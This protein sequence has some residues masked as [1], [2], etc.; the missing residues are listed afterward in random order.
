MTLLRL[1]A[2]PV[3][4]VVLL[5][6]A[7][8]GGGGGTPPGSVL[9]IAKAPTSGDNQVGPAGQ[10]LPTPLAAIVKDASSNPVAGQTVT[11]A[12]ASGG[13]SVNPASGTTAAS[14][15][16]TTV[17]T[18]GPGASSQTATAT[19]TSATGSPL[20]FTAVAQIQ[21][22]TQMALN[23]GSGQQDTI[24][25]AL[26]TPYSVVVRDQNNTAVPGVV[27]SWSASGGGSVSAATSTTNASGIASVTR[28]LGTTVGT[29]TAQ[30]AVTGLTGSP[31]SFT[32]TATAGN[33]TKIAISGGDNQTAQVNSTLL[34][35]YSVTARDRGDN[36]KSG[37]AVAWAVAS[38]GG[39]VNP[40]SSAT[41]ANGVAT[42]VRTL[43][44]TAGTQTATATAP[45]LTGSPLTFTATA[46]TAPLTGAVTVGPGTVFAPASVTIGVSGTVTW[47]WAAGS[48]SHGVQWLTGSPLPA[49]SA[50]QSSGTYMVTFNNAGTYTYDCLVHGS[51]M[52]GTIIVQ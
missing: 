43:G 18:L 4:G 27:V 2:W 14:G 8:G 39:S 3:V 9:T 48:L 7:C 16:A 34:T 21:G 31:V 24:G 20:T 51:S 42:T 49:N 32:A 29:H 23:A 17:L 1:A 40:T 19:H 45:G 38:G 25:A 10:A 44:P 15:I 47:T 50:I 30:A 22:A 36:V 13:G 12:A 28:T 46:T 41:N 35:P 52:S 26:A 11:W 37:V 5:G 6:V 33:A